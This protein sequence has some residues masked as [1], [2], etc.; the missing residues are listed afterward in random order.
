VRS[1]ADEHAE[2]PPVER[3]LVVTAH[4]DDVDFGAAGTVARWTDAGLTVTYCVCTD[5]QAGGFDPGLPRERMPEIRRAEQRAAAACVGVEDVRFLGHVDGELEPSRELVREL[6]R[7]IR[8]VRPDRLLLQ[9]PD[10]WWDRIGASH[11][12]HLAAG[13]AAI[14]AVYPFAR[15]PFAFPELLADGLEPWTVREVWVMA[16]PDPTTWVDVTDTFERKI[17]AIM[18]HTSQHPEP[19]A[20]RDWV[21]GWLA[22]NAERGGLDEGRLAES[23]RVHATG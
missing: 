15:N 4:P 10:R 1:V 11:P 18:A 17:E 8:D 7:V 16:V 13:E 14:R 23:F 22:S 5:G 21:A 19:D 12:D 2:Q 20:V 3:V 9:N 6:V